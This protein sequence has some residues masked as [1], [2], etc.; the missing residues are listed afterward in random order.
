MTE[1][2]AV[3]PQ[4][5]R[6]GAKYPFVDIHNHQ[7]LMSPEQVDQLVHDMDSIN[8]RVMVNL[9]AGTATAWSRWSRP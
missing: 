2:Y 3:V 8:L 1:V 5:P 7:R 4:H 6:T 9:T